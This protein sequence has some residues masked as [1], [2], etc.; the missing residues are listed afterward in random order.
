MKGQSFTPNERVAL[1][2]LRW[3][4]TQDDLPN[5]EKNQYWTV[6]WWKGRAYMQKGKPNFLANLKTVNVGAKT[7]NR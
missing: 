7:N 1:V 6:Y 4:K 3:A 2:W 5:Q